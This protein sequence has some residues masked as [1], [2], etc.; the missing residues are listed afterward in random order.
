MEIPIHAHPG[1]GEKSASTLSYH[2]PLSAYIQALT[3]AGFLISGMEEWISNKES[4]GKNAKAENRARNEIP[5]FLYLQA[6]K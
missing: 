6:L 2:L 4:T 3:N 5:L 1:Q